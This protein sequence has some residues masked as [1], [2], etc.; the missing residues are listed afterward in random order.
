[1]PK[2]PAIVGKGLSVADAADALGLS[3][4]DIGFGEHTPS[5]RAVGGAF[6]LIPLASL[7]ALKRA[8]PTASFSHHVT[9][10]HP[11][12]FLY[13]PSS[14][15]LRARMYGPGLGIAEDP[16][17]GSAVACLAGAL[18]DHDGLADGTHEFV[19]E[20]GV[21]MG[22]ASCIELQVMIEG[23]KLAGAEIGG[24]AVV[25]AEGVLHG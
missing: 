20:Q 2:L 23:G 13:A 7:D 11:A 9:G 14:Q 1:V 19:I 22:R 5:Q 21:E 16:A 3:A 25:V 6:D 10:D 12:V 24:A 4:A 18:A 15:G 8:W 17:T